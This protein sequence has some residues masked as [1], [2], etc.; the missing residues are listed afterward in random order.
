MG[1]LRV[2]RKGSS[3][4]RKYVGGRLGVIELSIMLLILSLAFMVRILPLKWGLSLSEFDPWFQFKQAK[5][6]V[7][8]GWKGFLDYFSW[9]DSSSWYPYG[10][11]VSKVAFPGLPFSLAFIHLSLS[12]IGVKVNLLELAAF[13]P[14]LYS[15]VA[16]LASY[17]IGS[18]VGGKP[19]GFMS[20]FFLALSSAYIGR[21][22]L[23]WFDDESIGIPLILVGLLFY[24]YSL[25]EDYSIRRSLFFA[26]LA[27]LS[28]G[29]LSAS[30]GAHKF[31]FAMIPLYTFLLALMGRYGKKLMVAYSTT[32]LTYT[33]I[34]LSVPK[35]GI[36]Y[37]SEATVFLGFI[38]LALLAGFGFIKT[39]PASKRPVITLT[40]IALLPLTGVLLLGLGIVSLPAHKFM[41][42]VA[43]FVREQSPIFVSV[44]ENQAATWATMF[45]DFLLLLPLSLFGLYYMVRSRDNA[46][47]LVSFYLVLSLY[48]S[49]SMVRLSIV[50][51]PAV[52][53]S[54]GY[55]VVRLVQA[56]S[57]YMAQETPARRRGVA[58]PHKYGIMVPSIV[59]LMIVYTFLPSGLGGVP[60]SPVDQAY[61]PVTIF[62]SSTP[63]KKLEP[64]WIKALNWIREN[65]PEDA[66]VASWW[67]YG[68]WISIL[69]NRTTLIDNG[70]RNTTQIGE[71]AY[72]FMSDEETGYRVFKRYGVTHVVVFVT[73]QPVGQWVSLLGFG[74]EGKWPWMLRIANQAGYNFTE[75][76]YLDERG[77]AT[78]KFWEETL[79]GKLIPFR[80][81]PA[82]R[83]G[84]VQGQRVFFYSPPE[85][86]KFEM[87]YFS[88][89]VSEQE[90]AYV[91]I[92]ELK[93]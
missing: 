63:I 56:Y 44:A 70:T 77:Q 31:P 81:I 51:A 37:I 67:D 66:I 4:V 65:L 30:W 38:V 26:F 76:D 20:A 57:A 50:A 91:Y 53:L 82:E 35:L 69:G 5:F 12:S 25:K 73:A 7:E 33:S 9:K 55:G 87:V 89:T 64:A 71:I 23:G 54:A 8:R 86:E 93:D 45:G 59:L 29:Y 28:L 6:I 42:V 19:V 78:D 10:T 75:G 79:I 47:L 62:S 16:V 72:A 48:F 68:Y 36:Y 13:L 92:Y 2:Y 34:A 1:L 40:L 80:P 61:F 15:L 14:P 41:S 11:E 32:L 43:P 58:M 22:T 90:I 46:S 3:L 88:S 60:F 18:M 17:Y 84:G 39:L 52:A 85:L 49:S 21:S 27:G 24:L 83:F 74:D